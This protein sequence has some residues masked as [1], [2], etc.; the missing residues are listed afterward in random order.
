[1]P[2]GLAALIRIGNPPWPLR[3]EW[4]L[5]G[6]TDPSD[7][8]TEERSESLA[9]RR[10]LLRR[11]YDWTI[12][13]ADTRYAPWAL[14]WLAFAEAFF[15]PVPADVLLI[16]MA[17]A[18][19]KKSLRYAAICTSGSILGGSVGYVIGMFFFDSIGSRL[20]DIFNA[21]ERY[22][23]LSGIVQRWGFWGVLFAA[24]TPF[25]YMIFTVGSGAFGARFAVFL[26]A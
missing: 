21:W 6:S 24:V 26:V 7:A 18:A 15:F 5:T 4:K 10:G 9:R 16:A 1:M 23:W 25:P 14:F 11:L 20:F 3:Q 19:P 8:L 2:P 12:H 22:E 17:L 13:W